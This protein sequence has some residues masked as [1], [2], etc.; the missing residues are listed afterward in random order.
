MSGQQMQHIQQ[1]QQM[2][3]MALRLNPIADALRAQAGDAFNLQ[4][5]AQLL[6]KYESQNDMTSPQLVAATQYAEFIPVRSNFPAVVGTSHEL[7]RKKGTGKGKTY[8]GSGNDIPLAEVLYD[9]LSLGVKAGVIGYRYSIMELAT[10]GAVGI[11][12][13]G[14][15]ISAAR[16]AF[17]AHMSD[18]A[19]YGEKETNLKGLLNQTGVTTTAAALAWEEATPDEILNDLN[20]QIEAARKDSEFNSIIEP[21]TFLIPTSLQRVLSS[22]RLS[23]HLATTIYEHIVKNN[24]LAL[25][26]KPFVIRATQRLED[27]GV[28]KKRRGILYRRDPS[29]LEMRIPQE[30][31]F[32]AGQV[33]GLE[34]SFPGH[35]LY[36]GVWLKR[37]DSMRYLDVPQVV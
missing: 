31:M 23:D 19:W 24:L 30:L 32:L 35:Y 4:T 37:V 2:H 3:K 25:E 10:A 11:D 15:K 20:G 21:D 33:D 16:L 1:V 28:G 22:R 29:C 8:A 6:V 7:Q 5:L 36:Q 14:D 26:G 34:V 13:N 18:V 12:L 17:E 9:S 27:A